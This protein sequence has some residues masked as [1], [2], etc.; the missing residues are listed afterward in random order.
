MARQQVDITQL[1]LPELQ[2]LQQQLSTEVGNFVNNMVTLQ[3][4]A[5]KFAAAGQSVEHLKEQKQGQP[6]LLPMT[7]S[8]YVPGTL[9]SVDT[10][11]LEIGTGYYVEVREGELASSARCHGFVWFS[12]PE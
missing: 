6:V 7:E 9:E 4:T 2:D 12:S 11:L 8:L 10:V 3:Q 5:A 1:S